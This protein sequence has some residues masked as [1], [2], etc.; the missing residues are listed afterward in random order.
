VPAASLLACLADTIDGKH[1]FLSPVW[2]AEP[3]GWR[4]R[5]AS[6]DQPIRFATAAVLAPSE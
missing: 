6:G 3:A 4:V 2:I 1:E 5:N